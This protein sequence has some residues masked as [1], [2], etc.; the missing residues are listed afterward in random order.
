VCPHCKRSEKLERDVWDGDEVVLTAGTD[1]VKPAGCEQCMRTG[2]RGRTGIFEVVELDD[3]LRE[4]V[5][6]KA[7]AREYRE[8]YARRN[9]VSLRRAGLQKIVAGVTT[10]EEV[11]R[12]T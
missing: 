9:I 4:L 12:V 10:V 8:I 11:L 3:E 7:P 6:A 2:Y 5:K 1:V